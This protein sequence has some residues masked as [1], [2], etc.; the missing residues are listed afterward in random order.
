MKSIEILASARAKVGKKDSKALR[1]N[2]QV[3]CVLYGGKETIHFS[4]LESI[5]KDAVYTHNVY[6][7]RLVIDGKPY[8]AIMKEIQFHPVTDKIQHIDFFEISADR[9]TIIDLPVELFGSSVGVREG[10]K[11]RQR[12]RYLK[13]KGL[14]ANLP[15][16]IQ[17]DISE[18][19]I[20]QSVLAGDLNI[21]NLEI[22][23][24]KR[25][26]VVGVIS[27]RAAAKGMGEEPVAEAAAAPAEATEAATAPEQ[28]KK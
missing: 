24:P 13:V 3:P 21:E 11:L 25:A 19:N 17:I 2:K 28:P 7:I 5:F 15:D 16:S 26:A 20:G 6:L 4:A 9:P 27:S 8:Q 22:L 1:K 10:G 18:L 14:I 23:E 12:K